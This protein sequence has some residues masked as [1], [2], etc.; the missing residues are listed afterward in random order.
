MRRPLLALLLSLAMVPAAALE[1]QG[2][3]EQGNL[4]FGRAE[5]GARVWFRERLLRV[6]PQGEFVLGLDRD[7]PGEVEL[8]VQAPGEPAPQTF[9][10]GVAQREWKVQHIDGLPQDK[11]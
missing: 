1:L 8:K 3:W 5:P 4:I 2:H 7:E 6:S 11:V 9:R 10:Y